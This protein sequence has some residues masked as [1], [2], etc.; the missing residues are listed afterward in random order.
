MYGAY[1]YCIVSNVYIVCTVCDV[2]TA[3]DMWNVSTVNPVLTIFWNFIYNFSFRYISIF[4]PALLCIVWFTTITVTL[5]NIFTR[6]YTNY[7]EK[8]LSLRDS[9]VLLFFVV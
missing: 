6:S 3:C 2:Y 7:L 1:N 9:I 5:E 8:W 4:I